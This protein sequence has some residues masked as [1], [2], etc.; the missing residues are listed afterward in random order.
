MLAVSGTMYR[1]CA[2]VI[3]FLVTDW[4]M[5]SKKIS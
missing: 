5:P 2:N 3:R 4:R 1:M